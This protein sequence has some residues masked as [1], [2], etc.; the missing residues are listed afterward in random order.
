MPDCAFNIISFNEFYIRISSVVY[1]EE[2]QH[3]CIH[4]ETC[5]YVFSL[6]DKECIYVNANAFIK[7]VYI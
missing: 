7:H 3:I 4:A 2:I 5:V 6:G 1:S